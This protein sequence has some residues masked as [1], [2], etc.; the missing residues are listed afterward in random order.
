MQFDRDNK[1]IKLC[2]DG[3]AAEG[4]GQMEIAIGLFRRAWEEA[5]ND[6]ERF[7]AAHYVAR[8]QKT[9]TDKL[10]WDETT[11]QLALNIDEESMKAYYPSLYLNIAKCYEDLQD[12]ENAR[13]NYRLALSFADSLPPDG[14]GKMIRS[15]IDSG[16]ERVKMP[17]L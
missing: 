13:N 10:K 2:A 17:T 14:Y 3:M 8:H 7:T 11:L 12:F 1:V 4:Q 9:V 6:F 15:G 16:V 5:S